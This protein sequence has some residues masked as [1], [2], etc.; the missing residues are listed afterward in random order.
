MVT[1]RGRTCFVMAA[2]MPVSTASWPSYLSNKVLSVSIIG[3]HHYDRKEALPTLLL[4]RVAP[5]KHGNVTPEG[6]HWG[7]KEVW[8]IYV[9]RAHALW[10]TRI[11]SVL[12][13]KLSSLQLGAVDQS[14]THLICC[15]VNPTFSCT[16]FTT[17]QPLCQWYWIICNFLNNFLNKSLVCV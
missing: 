8:L 10:L 15:G 2:S 11:S 7:P 14:S 16:I 3:R 6:E 12:T 9:L 13:F 17:D 4:S 5:A 1:H